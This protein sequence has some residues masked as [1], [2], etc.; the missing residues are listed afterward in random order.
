M[1]NIAVIARKGG[2]GKTTL[3]VHLAIAAHQAG[4]A[5]L[6]VDTDPQKSAAE[7][8]RARE[9]S[10]PELL[11]SP[12]DRLFDVH[13]AASD[14][15]IDTMIIDTPAA[16]EDEI[17][18]AIALAHLS[19]LV[20]R[21]TFLDIAASIQTAR[22][23]HRLRKPGLIVLSQ[24][25]VTRGGVEPPAVKKALEALRLMQLPVIPSIIRSRAVYQ[26]SLAL[27]RSAQETAPGSLAA[28]E[29]DALWRYLERFVYGERRHKIAS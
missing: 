10:G 9:A 22:L 7:V 13:K 11:V 2:S 29:M 5:T 24:A 1:K 4:H 23:L 20:I 6:L 12:A 27:G 28:D 3:A 21:P 18:H 16:A 19:V 14:R 17:A 26:T 25:P 15:Q 8:M